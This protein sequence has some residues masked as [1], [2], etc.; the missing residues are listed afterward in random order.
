MGHFFDPHC[1]KKVKSKSENYRKSESEHN[2]KSESGQWW[3]AVG[4]LP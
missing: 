1:S 3:Q 2:K 4:I